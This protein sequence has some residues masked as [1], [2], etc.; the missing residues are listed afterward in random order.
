MRT[1]DYITYLFLN[2][3]IWLCA[4][5]LH[6]SNGIYY[7]IISAAN[8]V[9]MSVTLVY[10]KD[11]IK[12]S[13]KLKMA[14]AVSEQKISGAFLKARGR[15]CRSHPAFEF[16]QYSSGGARGP[17]QGRPLKLPMGW[18]VDEELTKSW[19][20]VEQLCLQSL[21]VAIFCCFSPTKT[22]HKIRLAGS[23]PR[24]GHG[25]P[26]FDTNISALKLQGSFLKRS[27]G[28]GSEKGSFGKGVFSEKSE[29]SREFRDSRE[30]REP[31][32]CGKQKRIRP[33]S[34]DSRESRDFRDSRDCSSEK[35]PFIMTPFSG[36]DW[37][38]PNSGWV[39]AHLRGGNGKGGIRICLPVHCLSAPSDRQP[40]C[41]R[42]ATSSPCWR[43][44]KLRATIACQYSVG[45]S[46]HGDIV[47]RSR[48]SR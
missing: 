8:L 32:G 36:P 44:T 24:V 28:S 21:A 23:S 22:A 16:Y 47:L 3:F 7:V 37:Q 15:F 35:T 6:Y 33:L 46:R 27:F 25:L 42:N 31:T 14:V 1:S 5:S 43:T 41:H 29:F 10:R 39:R 38:H 12:S 18:R 2:S 34:R 45:T 26:T 17:L 9:L 30:S 20:I 13:E 19:P 40:Y 11:Q 48:S 4:I